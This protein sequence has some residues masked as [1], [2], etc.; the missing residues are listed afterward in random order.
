M[1]VQCLSLLLLSS[2]SWDSAETGAPTTD[3]VAS[4][5]LLV[6]P[7]NTHAHTHTHTQ[8]HEVTQ[9]YQFSVCCHAKELVVDT[10]GTV[11]FVVLMYGAF[12]SIM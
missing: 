1:V 10:L 8:S 12:C 2:W 7:H 5:D 4:S 3:S 11:V 6:A 9:D